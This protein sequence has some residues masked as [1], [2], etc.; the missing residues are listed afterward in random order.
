MRLELT[1]EDADAVSSGIAPLHKTSLTEFLTK[2][3]EL[4]E[5]QYVDFLWR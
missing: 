3:L 1:K 4:E 2:G 5:Q